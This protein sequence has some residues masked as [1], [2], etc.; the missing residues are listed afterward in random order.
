VSQDLRVIERVPGVEDYRRLRR[1]VG[2]NDVDPA[3]AEA[4]LARSLASFCLVDD[5][6]EVLGVA[7]V[8]GDDGVYFYVQDVIVD[9]RYR[10]RGYGRAL[11]DAV[12]R[13]LSGAARP[14]AFIGLMASRDVAP[15]YER[16]GFERRPD[17]RP[18]MALVWR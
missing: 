10:G 3:A 6:N 4:A 11:M 18:G 9:E 7:R 16:Y 12:M 8:V 17:D 2:W 13:Y 5:R 15:F 14:G 1:A